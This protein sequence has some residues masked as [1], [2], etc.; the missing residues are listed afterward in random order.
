[1]T[2]YES[3]NTTLVAL[4]EWLQLSNEVIVVKIAAQLYTIRDF[5]K[6]PSDILASLQRVKEIGYNAVQVSGLGPIDAAE[7]KQ[8]TDDIGLTICATHV[9]YPQLQ[10]DIKSVIEVHQLWNCK[11]VGIGS[12]PDSYRSSREGYEAFAR[13]ASEYGRVLAKEGLKL[14]YHNHNFEYAKFDGVTGMDILLQ[15]FDPAA[16]DFEL[17]VYWVQA[18]GADPVQWIRKVAGRMKAPEGHGG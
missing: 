10:S 17:D 2:Q 11:Y 1:M 12:M 16:V 14:I 4:Y 3:L 15:T 9:P 13:E 6:T 8:M 7:L 5:L 18:G